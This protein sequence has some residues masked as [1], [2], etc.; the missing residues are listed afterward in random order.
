MKGEPPAASEHSAKTVTTVRDRSLTMIGRLSLSLSAASFALFLAGGCASPSGG[1]TAGSTGTGGTGG[2]GPPPPGLGQGGPFTFPQNKTSGACTI[3]SVAN[4]A[5]GTQ[6]A[7]NSWKSTFVTSAGAGGFLRVQSPQHQGGT[8]SEGIGYGMIAAVYMYDRPTFD[9][10]WGYAQLHFDG[11][12]LMNWQI[13][14]TG[15]IVGMNSATDADEDIAWA[16]LMASDQ[17]SSVAYLDDARA[18]IDAIYGTAIAGD[19]TIKPDKYG[20]TNGTMYDPDYFSPA[21]YRVFARA[22][23]NPAWSG[24][25]I[26]RGYTLLA[27]VSGSHGL[28]PNATTSNAPAASGTY[29][30]N[31]CRG[32]WRIAMDYCFNGEAR[33]KAYLDKAGMFFSGISGGAANIG[34]GYDVASGNQ[35]S[36]NHNMAFIGPAGVVGMAGWQSL[37]DG[38]FMFGANGAGDNAYFTNSL[39]VVSMIM[40]SGNLLDYA[41]Q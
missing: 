10:L 37:L 8:V 24:V 34:D 11:D 28:M 17:W 40:M 38:A 18:V 15:S 32:P 35:T 31:A 9:G 20:G 25:I 4:A 22:T 19:G 33:A 5:A 41:H 29:G 2:S 3:T 26:D 14:S 12:G 27:A 39:R 1:G 36:G 13:S 6:S 16:L 23:D 21:Y 7:Y 30:Y